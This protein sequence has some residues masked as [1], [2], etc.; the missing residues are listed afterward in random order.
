MG[1]PY[2]EKYPQGTAVRIVDRPNLEEF[3]RTWRYHNPIDLE[4]M[5]HAGSTALV[6]SVGFYHGGD[7]LYS[8]DGLPGIWHESCLTQETD[9]RVPPS[10][11][12]SD[13]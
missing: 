9:A 13:N 1:T 3:R 7:P 12:P 8:L 11:P 5:E 10:K 2:Q 6:A 4:Q